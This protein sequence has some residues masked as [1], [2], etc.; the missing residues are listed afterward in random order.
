[1]LWLIL[2]SCFKGRKGRRVRARIGG[3]MVVQKNVVWLRVREK[4]TKI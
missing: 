2:S 4:R 3:R 1:M